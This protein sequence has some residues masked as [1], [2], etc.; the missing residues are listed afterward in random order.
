MLLWQTLLYY[1]YVLVQ[2]ILGISAGLTN[3]SVTPEGGGGVVSQW[4]YPT[5]SPCYKVI[6]TSQHTTEIGQLP[7]GVVHSELI[8]Y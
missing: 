1:D 4:M 8:I 5:P 6:C 3:Y 2:Y 7:V